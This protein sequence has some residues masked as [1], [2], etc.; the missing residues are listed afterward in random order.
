MS[1]VDLIV[2]NAKVLTF[3]ANGTEAEAF[4]AANG[5]IV[6]V[7]SSEQIRTSANPGARIL[8]ANGAT[9][10]PGFIDVHAHLELLTY[11]TEIAVDY[12]TP[13]CRTIEDILN[14][15]RDR[16]A[17]TPKAEWI[18][19]QGS[20][21]QDSL[22]ED[23]RYPDRRDLDRVSGDHPILARFSGHVQIFNTL[24][25][26]KVGITR[27]TP[28]PRGGRIERDDAGDPTGR[29]YDLGLTTNKAIPLPEWPF[30]V[31]R[32]GIKKV[33][34]ERY[35]ANGVTT[36]ADLQMQS[37]GT[38]SL[39]DLYRN[40]ELPLRIAHYGTIPTTLTRDQAVRGQ[41]QA[42]LEGI[43]PDWIRWGG[44]KLFLDGG[45][46]AASAAMHDPYEHLPGYR[47]EMAYEA[48]E[49]ADLVRD[50]DGAGHQILVHT[51]GDRA[52]DTALDAFEALPRPRPAEKGAHRLEHAGQL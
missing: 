47:G 21:M 10:V 40:N 38:R 50:L 31:V 37:N 20:H 26:N 44:I 49:F 4:A 8:D 33:A 7:G 51:V 28:H 17:S 23:R 52:I 5:R 30:E 39:L 18:L 6:A 16:A 12:R 46:T 34:L 15:L 3:D 9:V 48:A 13:P 11:A 25:L 2:H 24:G 22:L 32:A 27:D 45:L 41:G 19:G 42:K 29:T 35:V 1:V 36:L 14:R 43:D